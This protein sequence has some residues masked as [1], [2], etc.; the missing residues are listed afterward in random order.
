LAKA[1]HEEDGRWPREANMTELQI[2]LNA[3]E[4]QYLLD[5]LERTL[6]DTRVEEH[7]TRTPTYREYVLQQEDIIQAVL[8]KLRQSPA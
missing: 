1:G 4:R 7:R 6:K 5:L 2:T 8:N 3:D